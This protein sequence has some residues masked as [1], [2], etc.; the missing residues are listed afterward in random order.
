MNIEQFKDLLNHLHVAAEERGVYVPVLAW[1]EAGIGKSESVAAVAKAL[2]LDCVDLRLGTQEVGDLIGLPRQEN[3]YPCAHCIESAE[4]LPTAKVRFSKPELLEHI[5]ALHLAE[6]AD[7]SDPHTLLQSA[8]DRATDRYSHLI[9]IRTVHTKP[10]W[11]PS[12][13]TSGFLFLDELNRAHMEVLQA[14]FQLI[15]D[16]RMH[17]HVL[18][19]GWIII[20]AVNPASADYE[21]NDIRDKALIARFMHI[22]FEPSRDEWLAYA[23]ATD[24]DWSI[25]ALIAEDRKFLGDLTAQLPKVQPTP[26]TWVMLHRILEDLPDDLEQEVA[27]GLVGPEAAAAWLK[28]RAS[29]QRPVKALDVFAN[30]DSVRGRVKAYAKDNRLDLLKVTLDDIAQLAEDDGWKDEWVDGLVRFVLDC[31][32]DLAYAYLKLRFIRNPR[33]RRPLSARDDLY[34]F[35][36]RINKTAGV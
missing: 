4:D 15:L 1:G 14:V 26:R 24:V 7:A 2:E 6:V 9:D 13:G 21:T 18:P 30:Y 11:F 36:S 25:R 28:L 5:Q 8:L 34:E 20:S 3:W 22:G 32:A 35:V 17:A 16:R 33:L 12:E 10:A 19:K 23:A 31:P 27:A 29:A